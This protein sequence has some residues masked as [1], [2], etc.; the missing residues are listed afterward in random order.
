MLH[1]DDDTL[2]EDFEKLAKVWRHLD[3]EINGDKL[4]KFLEDEKQLRVD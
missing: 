4:K 1:G 3:A 2:F